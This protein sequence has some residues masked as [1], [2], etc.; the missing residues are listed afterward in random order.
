M[1]MLSVLSVLLIGSSVCRAELIFQP[2]GLSAGDQYRLLFTTS[3]RIDATSGDINVY[4]EF[5][6]SVADAAPVVGSWGLDWRAIVSTATVHASDNADIRYEDRESG[7][8]L[9]RVDGKFLGEIRTFFPNQDGGGPL[10]RFNVTE[11]DTEIPPDPPTKFFVGSA[12]WIGTSSTGEISGPLG[13]PQAGTS[14]QDL[15]AFWGGSFGLPNTLELPLIAISEV[16]TVVPE[17]SSWHLGGLALAM[18]TFRKRRPHR[19]PP[20]HQIL[21]NYKNQGV[22]SA[23]GLRTDTSNRWSRGFVAGRGANGAPRGSCLFGSGASSRI[24]V[25]QTKLLRQNSSLCCPT[26]WLSHLRIRSGLRGC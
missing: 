1:K 4:N 9:Y 12:V 13:G 24:V 22:S 19:L 5:V 18:M 11:L 20:T 10:V 16:I 7:M 14:A 23:G 8:K 25:T 6:Q 26:A 2:D 21:S 17:P 3:K 15:A